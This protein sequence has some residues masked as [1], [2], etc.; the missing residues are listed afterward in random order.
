MAKKQKESKPSVSKL[1]KK[2]D[3]IFSRFIRLRD[4]DKKGFIV[5]PLCWA[6]IFWKLAQCMHFITRG[7]KLYRY[8]EI[9]CHAGCKRCNVVL[10]WN[11]IV[12]T[13]WM[14][15]KYWLEKVE[16]MKLNSKK[17]H[18]LKTYELESMI[19]YY[20]AQ[21]QD[22]AKEKGISLQ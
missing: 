14:I 20:S 21:V 9:N 16:E 7:C 1:I 6:K 11:Y 4:C 13:L 18:K 3:A 10:H 12:Y 2:L 15:E 8:D 5:C 22:L 17:T 19:D